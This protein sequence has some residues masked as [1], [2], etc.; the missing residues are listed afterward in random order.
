MIEGGRTSQ[1]IIGAAAMLCEYYPRNA[2]IRYCNIYS[3]DRIR[4]CRQRCDMRTRKSP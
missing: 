2:H 1:S 4:R 3:L